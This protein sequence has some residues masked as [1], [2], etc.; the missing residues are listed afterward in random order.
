MKKFRILGFAG[1]LRERS[2]NRALLRAAK[3][4]LPNEIEMEIVSLG[5][6]PLYNDDL[7]KDN[8]PKP[9]HIFREKVENADGLLIASPEY[10]YSISGVLKNA[11]DWASTNTIGNT[12][13]GKSVAIMGASSGGFGTTRGQL[14]LR[15]VL[16]AVNAKVLNRP[17]V[18]VRNAGEQLDNQGNLKDPA[19][20]EDI[21][22]L[23]NALIGSIQGD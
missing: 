8:L 1:S 21:Q 10:N 7:A 6:L 16:F 5:N 12:M 4:Y 17:Q 11:I 22:R 23:L 13:D 2:F 14:H 15:T 3:E 18:L 20:I 19:T 9:V